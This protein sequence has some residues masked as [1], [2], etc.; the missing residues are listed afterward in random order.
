[1]QAIEQHPELKHLVLLGGG[2]A[3]VSVLKSLIMSPMAGLR[4]TLISRDILTPYSGMLPGYLEGLYAEKDITIDLS[5]LARLAGARFIHGTVDRLDADRRK[6]TVTGYPE[7]GYDLLS[8]N[9]GSSPDLA[10]IKGATDYAIPVKPIS[11]LLARLHPVLD[12][13]AHHQKQRVDQK[14]QVYQGQRLA[15]IGG[16]AGG[17]EMAL[18]LHHRL[19]VKENRGLEFI[20]IGRNA[21]FIAEFPARA[22]R[23]LMSELQAKNITCHLGAAVTEITKSGVILADSQNI[24]AD[25]VLAVTAGRPAKFL[26]DSGLALDEKGFIAV[27]SSLQ[28]VSHPD[29][30][31]A[32]DIASVIGAARP[33]AGVFAV[34]AGPILTQNL[35]QYLVGA[36]LKKWQPQQHYLALIGVGGRRAMAVRG[37][38]TLPPSRLLWHL[39]EWIDRKFI[40]KFSTLPEMPI[41][42]PSLL[43]QHMAKQGHDGDAALSAM[44]C[45][46]CGAKTGFSDLDAGIADAQ[47][48]LRDQG[49][50][51]E[52]RIKTNA[53][54][55]TIHLSPNN[56]PF[57]QIVQS[58]DAISALVDDPFLL[59][60]IAALHAMS[61]LFASH[62]KPH[63][64]LAILTLPHAFSS[65][66]K[67]DITQI[68]AGAMKGFHDHGAV[69]TGGHTS[70]GP[71]LQVG[72]AVTGLASTAE[73]Y[74]PQDGDALILTKP[75]G[76]GV[77]MA[78]HA[79]GHALADGVARQKAIDVMAQSNGYAAEILAKA[80]SFPMTDVTGFGLARH[81]L[82]LLSS[83]GDGTASMVLD[84]AALPILSPALAL[85]EDGVASSLYHANQL[86]AHVMPLDDYHPSQP[87]LYDPQTG[88]GLLAIVPKDKAYVILSTLQEQ[89]LDPAL[90]GHISFDGLGMIRK[91]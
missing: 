44:R 38:M 66:Q 48:Y 54:S 35:R 68:L 64:A 6:L 23:L 21:R 24:K 14:Q 79:Q 56:Q 16:G 91:A 17:V 41:P 11:Q 83:I 52:D 73:T 34:R 77:I 67:N 45:L 75:L 19:N 28:S 61:D 59:G 26:S 55:A 53:D 3:Q 86:A 57:N 32:G 46:G 33:K 13:L 78:G 27:D 42:K 31:A 22:S 50:I 80:G 12:D 60:R 51:L 36:A 81:G 30:F 15:I 87:L 9:I 5:H 37:A 71:A 43:A 58:V 8:V 29:V 89:Y 74:S 25:H 76:I 62:A 65:L 49:I 10:N 4:V 82:S 63:S 85:V 84:M 39:K 72:F 88:G 2:H 20:L 18:S 69:L 1:M 7:M 40:D 70:T 90:I 47:A